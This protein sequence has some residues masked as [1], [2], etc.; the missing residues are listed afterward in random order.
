[1]A[2]T[3]QSNQLREYVWLLWRRKWE[4]ILVAAITLGLTLFFTLRQ[5]KIYEAS[6]E[7]LVNATAD[8]NSSVGPQAPDLPTEQQVASSAAVAQLVL[9]SRHF[10]MSEPDLVSGLQVTPVAG[11]TSVLSIAYQSA[12]P[13]FAATAANAFARAY[14]DFRNGNLASAYRTALAA[15]QGDATSLRNQISRLGRNAGFKHD[16]LVAQLGVVTQQI[17]TL[18]N[19]AVTNENNAAQVIQGATVPASPIRPQKVRN[20]ILGLLGGLVLGLI[21][22]LFRH[23][24][25]VRLKDPVQFQEE[26][27][28]PV[29][30]AIPRIP[31]RRKSQDAIVLLNDSRSPVAEMYRTLATNLRYA[32]QEHGR[33]VILVTSAQRGEGK[34]TIAAN[35]AVAI[36]QSGQRVLLV[37]ADLRRP[38]LHALLDVSNAGIADVVSGDTALHEVIHDPGIAEL[39]FI[40]SGR[41]PR[42][43]AAL[44][45]SRPMGQLLEEIRNVQCDIVL[46]DA[47]PVL[48]VADAS[49]L[50]AHADAVLFVLDA[51]ETTRSALYQA[52]E[53]LRN[54]GGT[55]LGG[56]LNNFDPTALY[57]GGYYASAGA[58]DGTEA[59]DVPGNGQ[60]PGPMRR[61][62]GVLR[63]N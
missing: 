36:A 56:V 46:I 48:P 35:L 21:V 25:D 3:P 10:S 2:T 1:M 17:S 18:Q 12:S 20:V 41:T 31:G 50:A 19:A 47:P 44:L 62:I 29:F 57:S 13:R 15:A 61:S 55:V 42:D 45:G 14:V 5:T 39:R 7:I 4:I 63:R 37:S 51:H 22:A 9:K 34:S 40:G 52:R 49:I 33:R 11:T 38:R 30:G 6:T 43:P 27:R 59:A 60:A 32:A 16:N 54:A 26:L 53:Q 28:A 24:F 8:P 23:R 58:E